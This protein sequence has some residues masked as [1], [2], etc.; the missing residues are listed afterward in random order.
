MRSKDS[1]LL[2]SKIKKSTSIQQPMPTKEEVETKIFG[3]FQILQDK[4]AFHNFFTSY[5][6]RENEKDMVDFWKGVID[7]YYDSLFK[8]FAAI[9]GLQSTTKTISVPSEV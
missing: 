4:K 7:F 5:D 6:F 2:A 1:S 8:S 3:H 9:D